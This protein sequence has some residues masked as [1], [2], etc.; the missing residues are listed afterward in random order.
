MQHLNEKTLKENAHFMVKITLSEILKAII[1]TIIASVIAT[2]PFSGIIMGAFEATGTIASIICS[3]IGG[4][5]GALIANYIFDIDGGDYKPVSLYAYNKFRSILNFIGVF[6]IIS[7][8]VLF[9]FINIPKDS[10]LVFICTFVLG[11]LLGVCMLPIVFKPDSTNRDCQKCKLAFSR[12]KHYVGQYVGN[13]GRTVYV[14]GSNRKIGSITDSNGTE[15]GS[16]RQKT[17]GYYKEENWKEK[18]NKIEYSCIGCG[19]VIK[20]T[21]ATG[22][23]VK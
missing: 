19:S 5:I 8:I 6:G 3:I 20:T 14:P 22:E 2:F 21:E 23:R 4:T 9:S 13:Y 16:I 17:D 18:T 1:P 7:F 15:I 12:Q 11:A 10:D